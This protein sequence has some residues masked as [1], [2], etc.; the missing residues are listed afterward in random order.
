MFHNFYPDELS[1][2]QFHDLPIIS[3]WGNIKML[4]V[5]HKPTETTQLFQDSVVKSI[6]SYG[7]GCRKIDWS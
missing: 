2:G 4:P 5:L 6:F 3:L 7:V 1:S